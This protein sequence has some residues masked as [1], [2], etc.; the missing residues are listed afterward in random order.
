MHSLLVLATGLVLL[1]GA[2]RV[3]AQAASE[4]RVTLVGRLVN[5]RQPTTQNNIVRLACHREVAGSPGSFNPVPR[6]LFHQRNPLNSEIRDLSQFGLDEHE[7]TFMITPD[8]EGGFSC[9]D[10]DG[11]L[12]RKSAE[13]ELVGES[14]GRSGY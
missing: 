9:S 10:R 4:L 6:P 12:D 1:C 8:L 2:G 3:Q 5:A 14:T 11:D 13:I 7:I